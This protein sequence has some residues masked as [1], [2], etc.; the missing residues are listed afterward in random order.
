MT[1]I[2]VLIVDDDPMVRAGL[3]LMLRGSQLEVAGE[4]DDGQGAAAVARRLAADVVLMDIRMPGKDGIAAT[5]EV[6]QAC[7]G[8]KVL[9]LTTFDADELVVD[10]IRAG[11]SGFLLKD[12]APQRIVDAVLAVAAGEP[13]VSPSVLAQLMDRAARTSG[14][15]DDARRRLAG[16][17]PREREVADAVADGLTNVEIAQQLFLSLPTV[18]SH[19]SSILAKA[20]ADNRVQL[21]LLVQELR[22]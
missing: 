1:P 8:T 11:A 14:H 19:V 17:T 7:P 21:A 20:G 4:H 15:G 10:A 16:L 2:R 9:V 18:K 6:V 13:A 5:R 3:R 12:S 22:D